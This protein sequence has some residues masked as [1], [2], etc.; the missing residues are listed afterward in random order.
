MTGVGLCLPQ[1]GAGATGLVVR[2]FC[3]RAEAMGFTSLWVQE[4][5]LVPLRPLS[6]Y[7]GVPGVPIPEQYRSS[8][9]PLELLAAA[10][11]WTSTVRLGTSVLV[12][13]YH[14]P[15]QLAQRLATIDVLSGGRLVVGL[16]VGW[17][18]EE[19]Q[20]MDVATAVRGRRADELVA[21]LHACWGDD[22][23]SYEG[24][25]FSIPPC[26]LNP[27]PI[28]RPHPLLIA[29]M[30]SPAGVRRTTRLF[31]GWNPAMGS[32]RSVVAAVEKMNAQRPPGAPPLSI[33]YRQF[34][35]APFSAGPPDLGAVVES[36][37]QAV[38][39]GFDEVIID[40]NFHDAVREPGGWLVVLEELAPVAGV[41][42]PVTPAARAA[43]N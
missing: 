1:L 10:A 3:E 6:G 12:A 38:E 13:G 43:A 35:H 36:V 18:P 27:K 33:W 31:D 30:W 8:L 25:F 32:P 9:A 34:F 26:Y 4:H 14:R 21:A 7:G 22:P 17:S 5:M 20:Q 24:E 2:E 41:I 39:L 11:A 37:H 42:R 16:G 28:Q 40:A 15:V 23:V 29:G 19:H